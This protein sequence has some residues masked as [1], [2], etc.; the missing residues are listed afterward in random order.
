MR[1]AIELGQ[2]DASASS[3]VDILD[4]LLE[5]I[6]LRNNDRFSDALELV[7]RLLT[8]YPT[9]VK[10][11]NHK[12]VILQKMGRSRE[13]I[14]QLVVTINSKYYTP[15]TFYHLGLA[16]LDVGDKKRAAESL[17]QTVLLDHSYKDAASR[18]NKLTPHK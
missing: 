11:Y 6:I 8:R 15:E 13:A 14:E 10:L 12:G 16:Y 18:L 1:T 5:K 3:V 4:F 2:Q 7:E 17:K 9:H